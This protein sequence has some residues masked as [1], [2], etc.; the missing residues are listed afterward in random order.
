MAS[1]EKTII[2]SLLKPKIVLD[3]LALSD[4]FSSTSD[5]IPQSKPKEVTGHQEQNSVGTDYPLVAINNYTVSLEELDT[6]RIDCTGFLP[7]LF[8]SFDL[9]NST[10]FKSQAM[11]KD[12]DIVNVFI[13]AKNDVFKPVRNDYVIT[14]VDIGK[15]G[16]EGAGRAAR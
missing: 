3:E 2:R 9:V 6:F 5:K 10:T 11:P 12:G 14:G 15:G 7:R 4:V 8:L 16:E 13:R 1:D